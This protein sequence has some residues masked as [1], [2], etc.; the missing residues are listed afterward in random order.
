MFVDYYIKMKILNLFGKKVFFI[1]GDNDF[2]SGMLINVNVI[3]MIFKDVFVVE[4]NV[5][6]V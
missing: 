3:V 1:F 2:V 4:L 6:V 5:L